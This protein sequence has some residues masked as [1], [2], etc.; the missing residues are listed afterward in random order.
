MREARG[1]GFPILTVKR[2]YGDVKALPIVNAAIGDG[3]TIRVRARRVVA[4]DAAGIAEEMLGHARIE[5]VAD[6]RIFTL[7]QFEPA[8]GHDDVDIAGH[9]ADRAIAIFNLEAIGQVDFEPNCA[10]MTSAL[11]CCQIGH[12]TSPAPL[13]FR[14]SSPRNRR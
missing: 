7:Q 10:A 9:G 1:I 12:S 11:T 6:E 2:A 8:G 4:L 5:R 13:S 3:H 14:A